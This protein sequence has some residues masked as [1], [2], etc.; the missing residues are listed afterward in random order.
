MALTKATH[1]MI[2]GASVNVKDF[3]AVGDGV[4]DDTAAI[5]AAI[6][7]ALGGDIIIPN[8]TYLIDSVEINTSLRLIGQ[9][10]VFKLK[11]HSAA[12]WDSNWVNVYPLFYLYADNVSFINIKADLNRWEQDAAFAQVD[13]IAAHRQLCFVTSMDVDVDDIMFDSCEVYE[14]SHAGICIAGGERHYYLNCYF[15]D[16][17]TEA[18]LDGVAHPDV[19]DDHRVSDLIFRDSV[20]E[21]IG[22]RA[23]SSDT[24]DYGFSL[25]AVTGDGILLRAS[26]TIIDN[27]KFYNID[28][29][30]IKNEVPNKNILINNVVCQNTNISDGEIWYTNI[31]FSNALSSYGTSVEKPNNITVSNCIS[32]GTSLVGEMHGV[33]IKDNTFVI[34][35]ASDTTFYQACILITFQESAKSSNIKISGNTILTSNATPI[36]GIKLS[37]TTKGVDGLT[38]IDNR[39]NNNK[40]SIF[41]TGNYACTD[42]SIV[43]NNSNEKLDCNGAQI[44]GLFISSNTFSTISANGT[45]SD[46]LNM[47]VVNNIFVDV[48]RADSDDAVF[49]NNIIKNDLTYRIIDTA[50]SRAALQHVQTTA[51]E[52][53]TISDTGSIT[54][55][56][57]GLTHIRF[58]SASA[59]T[60]TDFTGE[61]D[62]QEIRLYFDN[63]NVTVNSGASIILSPA[64]N[65]T[66]PANG[67]MSLINVNGVW[68]ESSRSF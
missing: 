13:H 25:P 23:S 56:I 44:D 59:T 20:V 6:D 15:H 19:E 1:R 7:A 21:N 32:S 42:V 40:S 35:A 24:R 43:G 18:I 48:P 64:S 45:S 26:N 12:D 10:G 5:Q 36:H 63:G 38:I 37:V 30:A 67:F 33:H 34:N 31:Q 52:W 57:K 29:S 60:V 62:T 39:F 49:V 68:K 54:P 16:I 28:R 51:G 4:T 55:N 58:T 17:H 2:S 66:V 27:I 50:K 8:G 47:Q 9:G 53:H 61:Y 65:V 3:G 14:G 41:I 46:V 11:S 22:L